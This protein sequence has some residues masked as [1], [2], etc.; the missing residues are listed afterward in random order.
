MSRT[1]SRVCKRPLW[2]V[3]A[4]RSRI[5]MSDSK[6]QAISEPLPAATS[7]RKI[8]DWQALLIRR[9]CWRAESKTVVWT[10][11]CFDLLHVGHIRNL[12]AGRALGHVLV[13]G[14][15]SDDSIRLLKGPGRPIV[16]GD[17]RAEI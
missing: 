10:N 17:E 7:N 12:A 1:G 6:T 2:L 4:R 11:G 16:S 15:N 9:R 13:V 14:V 8:V 5:K 3:V